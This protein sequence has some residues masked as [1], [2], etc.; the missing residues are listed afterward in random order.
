MILRM[1]KTMVAK[2]ISELKTLSRLDFFSENGPE[3]SNILKTKFWLS[4]SN[5][6][7]S[8]WSQKVDLT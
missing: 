4:Q 1:G 8:D 6:Q 2:V 3:L 7:I 5:A